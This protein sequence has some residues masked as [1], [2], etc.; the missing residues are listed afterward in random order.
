MKYTLDQYAAIKVAV[1]EDG[2][3]LMENDSCVGTPLEY[4]EPIEAT[5]KEKKYTSSTQSCGTAS[6]VVFPY[7]PGG[8]N[9]K[10]Q[11]KRGAGLVRICLVCDD[12][13]RWPKYQKL[14]SEWTEVE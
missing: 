14:M 8:E 4:S 12:V 13:G 6:I 10:E 9:I 11:L 1:V 7:E 3:V 5:G 2:G